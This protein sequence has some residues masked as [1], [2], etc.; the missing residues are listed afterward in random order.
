MRNLILLAATAL[1]LPASSLALATT[2]QAR[3]SC[4]PTEFYRPSQN[5]CA[6]K[7]ANAA[8]YRRHGGSSSQ[9]RAVAT[10]AGTLTVGSLAGPNASKRPARTVVVCTT[11][12]CVQKQEGSE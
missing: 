10:A 5:A 11:E 1:A 9:R 3:P 4:G 7:A 12:D 2:A 8:L 6:S